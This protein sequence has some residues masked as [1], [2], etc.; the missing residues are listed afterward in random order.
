MPRSSVCDVL[1]TSRGLSL[2]AQCNLT[3]SYVSICV[4]HNPDKLVCLARQLN[5]PQLSPGESSQTH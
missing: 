1:G 2:I 3:I 4:I 5:A